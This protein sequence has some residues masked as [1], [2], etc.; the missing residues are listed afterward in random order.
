MA[1]ASSSPHLCHRAPT[2]T[3]PSRHCWWLD[4]ANRM[5]AIASQEGAVLVDFYAAMLPD[6]FRYIGVDGLHPN[7][8]GYA[9][10]AELFF[11]AIQ[12]ESRSAIG[13]RRVA[14]DL[15]VADRLTRTFGDRVAVRDLSLSVATGEIVALL[16]PNGAGKTTTMR[17]L[18]GLILPTAGRIIDRSR[19]HLRGHRRRAPAAVGLLTEAPGLWERLTVRFNLLTYAR[20]HGLADPGRAVDAVLGQV[21]LADRADDWPASCRRA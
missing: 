11:Q 1:R 10:M 13:C 8:A 3:G 9:K 19:R 14:A 17:M 5:R 6:V 18:A 2:A 4:Y 12:A 21:D 16:G 7:E 20:L 15:L